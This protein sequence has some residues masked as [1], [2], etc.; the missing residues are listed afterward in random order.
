MFLLRILIVMLFSGVSLLEAA[1]TCRSNCFN[2]F[3]QCQREG[4]KLGL[5]L[6][7]RGLCETT[8]TDPRSDLKAPCIAHCEAEF[9]YCRSD[10]HMRP[11]CANKRNFC[12][13]DCNKR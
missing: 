13:L 12:R 4:T 2:T 3:K 6:A 1:P 10:P 5:C 9:S 8:C 7:D 11:H